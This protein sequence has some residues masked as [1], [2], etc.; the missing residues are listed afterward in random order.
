MSLLFRAFLLAVLCF[1]AASAAQTE[2][3]ND[4]N[5]SEMIRLADA[6]DKKAQEMLAEAYLAGHHGL[7]VDYA[8]AYK[9][10]SLAYAQKSSVAARNLGI[11][12]LYGWGVKQ[13][14]AEA[15][16]LLSLAS[17]NGDKK[18]PR[19][20]GIIYEQGLGVKKDYALA[21]RYFS[22]GDERDDITSQYH[23]G[24]LYESGLGVK[25]DYKEG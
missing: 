14:Y 9:Y 16:K 10:S 25:R 20:I 4:M 22:L 11:L 2:N 5:A 24:K 13:D 3:K 17:S 12:Y 8:K 19:Y 23:L 21:V 1:G 18:A 15:M 7:S 6:G